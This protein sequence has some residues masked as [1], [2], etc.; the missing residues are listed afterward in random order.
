MLNQIHPSWK[1]WALQ[2]QMAI[3]LANSERN[4]SIVEPVGLETPNGQ[5]LNN[6]ATEPINF[7][8]GGPCNFKLS[9]ACQLRNGIYLFWRWWALR[10]QMGICFVEPWCNLFIL[11]PVGLESPS[12]HLLKQILIKSNHFEADGVRGSK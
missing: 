6:F 11:E 4:L 8:T 10:L 5:F 2:F 12:D 3:C 1:Q 9:F 7:G